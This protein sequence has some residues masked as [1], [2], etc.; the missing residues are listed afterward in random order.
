MFYTELAGKF[1]KYLKKISIK[2]WLII[3]IHRQIFTNLNVHN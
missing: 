2:V 1:D 3:K